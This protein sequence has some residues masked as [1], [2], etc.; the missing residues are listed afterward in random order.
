MTNESDLSVFADNVSILSV[1]ADLMY[2]NGDLSQGM[3]EMLSGDISH[4]LITQWK[5][6]LTSPFYYFDILSLINA[7]SLLTEKP[8][9][10][11]GNNANQVYH[12]FRHIDTSVPLRLVDT[13]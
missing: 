13:E 9:V 11:F 12:A 2:A 10:T 8:L 3:I 4:G 1:A 7:S 6:A 5:E